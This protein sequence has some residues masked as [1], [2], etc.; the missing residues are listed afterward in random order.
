LP[1]EETVKFIGLLVLW[2]CNAAYFVRIK[3]ESGVYLLV[4][5]VELA[6]EADNGT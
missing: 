4:R 6:I 5:E 2:Q 1:S 3:M